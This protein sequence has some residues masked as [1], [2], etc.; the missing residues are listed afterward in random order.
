M[1]ESTLNDS[2]ILDAVSHLSFILAQLIE[3]E[4][5]PVKHGLRHYL[6]SRLVKGHITEKSLLQWKY[7]TVK[8]FMNLQ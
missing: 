1:L 2:S 6:R 7:D 3:T 5:F 8:A 4:P